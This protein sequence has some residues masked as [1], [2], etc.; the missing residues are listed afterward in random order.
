MD[1]LT[2]LQQTTDGGYILGGI[3]FSAANGD[4]SQASQG[5]SDYWI[6]KIDAN[7]VK[8]WDARFGGTLFEEL[9]S[10]RQSVDGGYIMG[11]YSLSDVGGDKT[12]AARGR[13]D[14][15]VVKTNA[16]GI[17]Q[18]VPLLVEPKMIGLVN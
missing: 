14:Y 10:I 11:G 6:V 12:N 3:S 5:E 2:A 15:W 9:F 4:K 13:F 1:Q 16:N 17:K 18:W 7:G 8:Q